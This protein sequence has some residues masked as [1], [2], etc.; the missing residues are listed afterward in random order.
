MSPSLCGLRK[1]YNTQTCL[2]SMIEKWRHTLDKSGSAGVVLT[3]LSKSF[4]C[5]HHEL[6]I[7]KLNCYGMEIN[8]LRLIC[9]YLTGRWQRVRVNSSYSSWSNIL[10]GVPKGSVLGPILF[11]IYINDLFLFFT[12]PNIANYAFARESDIPTVLD[13]LHQDSTC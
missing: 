11:N 3:D 9:S 7:A 6:M 2:L 1:N 12:D 4:D 13:K 5:L 8:S 10:S